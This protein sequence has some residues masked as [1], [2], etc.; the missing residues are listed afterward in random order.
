[1]LPNSTRIDC[2]NDT[3]AVGRYIWRENGVRNGRCCG[4]DFEQAK[5]NAVCDD[6]DF[7]CVCN[8]NDFVCEAAKVSTYVPYAYDAVIALAHGLDKL[9]KEGY[10]ADQ[11][12]ASRLSR[13]IRESS[14]VGATGPVLFDENGDRSID[15][16]TYIVY[17]YQGKDG[18]YGFEEVGHIINERFVRCPRCPNITFHDGSHLRPDVRRTVRETQR[19]ALCSWLLA[20]ASS[21]RYMHLSSRRF[22]ILM[23]AVC[24]LSM[25]V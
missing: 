7:V 1:M 21:L 25:H 19:D 8:G 17:N 24:N 2:S 3:D 5:Q 9:V 20:R 11:M 10:S 15:D 4:I 13:A 18:K 22:Y 14:F 6:D 23:R 16:A 12:T